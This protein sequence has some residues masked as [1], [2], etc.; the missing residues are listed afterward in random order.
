MDEVA[1]HVPSPVL[2]TGA[3][4]F[5][6]RRLVDRLISAGFRVRVLVLPDD[7]VPA[8]WHGG[9]NVITGDISDP[10][11]VHAAM[12]DCG[13][14][15]HLAAVVGDWGPESLYRSVTVDGTRYV[16]QAAMEQGTRVVLASSIVVY[17]HHLRRERCEESLQMGKPYGPYSRSKQQQER[18]A[19]EFA[20]SSGDVRIVRPANVYG[21]HSGPWVEEAVK[22]LA[23]GAPS[24]VSGGRNNAGLVHVDNVVD[25]MLRAAGQ[26]AESGD[27]FNACDELP[28]TWARYFGDLARL[29]DAPA[30]KSLPAWLV[31][32][33]ARVMESGG[34][35]LRL[36]SRPTLTREAVNLISAGNDIP[37]KRAREVLGH[38]TLVGYEAGLAGI[39][40]SLSE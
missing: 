8:H 37:A 9:A 15:F 23:S 25:I 24:L 34:R 3:T 22:V 31:W 1:R 36:Q 20:G 4:G 38:E 19:A 18:L 39:A 35:A 29:V 27:V 30:P 33:L 17:G 6:G 40:E 10:E 11:S 26:A 16:F 7:P 21:P 5:I 14:V 28:V 2:V 12:K 13:A 32:S